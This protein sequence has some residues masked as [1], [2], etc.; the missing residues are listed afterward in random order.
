MTVSR[1]TTTHNKSLIIILWGLIFAKCFTLEYFVQ[2][3]AVPINSVLYVWTLTLSMAAVA[4]FVF[5]RI[6]S[7]D[8]N[9]QKSLQRNLVIWGTS[10]IAMLIALVVVFTSQSINPYSI[11]S[12]LAAF[13]GASYLVQSLLNSS[14][15]DTL[16]GSG[17]LIGAGI[18]FVQGAVESLILFA[19]LI[20][21]LSVLPVVV[22]MIRPMQ[23][24]QQAIHR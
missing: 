9:F 12:L 24:R 1:H 8:S 6:K 14:L 17:W 3:Y 22:Q 10:A 18:L 16:S 5:L 19:F 4:S 21:A 20:L 11:P 2:V 23:P 13:L 7:Q 15:S